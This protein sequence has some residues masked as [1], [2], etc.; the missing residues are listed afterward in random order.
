ML[1]RE[2]SR[3]LDDQ[4]ELILDVEFERAVWL[5]SDGCGPEAARLSARSVRTLFGHVD[6]ERQPN[7][8]ES[9]AQRVID[10]RDSI[11]CRRDRLVGG[12]WLVSGHGSLSACLVRRMGR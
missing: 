12:R 8:S 7:P 3:G 1:T 9:G 2:A 11:G 10:A 5:L 6:C 4:P